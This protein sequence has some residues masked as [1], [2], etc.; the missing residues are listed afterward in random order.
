MKHIDK[1]KFINLGF[2]VK[3]KIKD[4]NWGFLS[5]FVIMGLGLLIL[6]GLNQVKFVG[7]NFSFKEILISIL[8][9]IIVAIEEEVLF[10]GYVLR[11]FMYS[12]NKYIA[13]IMSSLLF[14]LAHGFN[15]N[16]D[17]F[18]YLDLFLAGV[19]LGIS[20]IYTKNLWFPIALHFSW[21]F[22]QTLFG[23][24]VSGQKFY[25]LIEF[26]ITNKNIINGGDFG[27]EGLSFL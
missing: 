15:P 16:M 13:L 5:G 9:Y 19:L 17:W 8:V 6:L 25:S 2:Q 14:A 22:F 21:N 11:N 10:R 27:F 12:F 20:Y 7:L 4:I 3:N 23:F 24:N 1:E 26:K 18:S